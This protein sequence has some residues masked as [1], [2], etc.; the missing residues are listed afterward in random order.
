MAT[1]E[2]Y[3]D[4]DRD[5]LDSAYL[6]NSISSLSRPRSVAQLTVKAYKQATHFFLTKRF[7]EALEQL[8]PIVTP[9]PS[10]SPQSNGGTSTSTSPIEA[11]SAP[12]TQSNKG[13]RTKVWVF[14]FSLLNAIIELG[15]DEGKSSFGSTKWRQLLAKAT[16]GSIWE[17]VVQHGYAGNEGDV[18]PD[19]VVNLATLLL[20]H[21]PDQR[22][23]QHRLETYLSASADA[24]QLSFMQQEGIATPM[25]TGTSSPKE[26]TTRLKILELYTLHV[27]PSNNEWEYAKG[28]IEMNDMLDEEHREAFL[29]ALATLKDEKE[30]L[31]QRE[32]ELEELREREMEEQ[33]VREEARRKDQERREEERKKAAEAERARRPP[34]TPSSSSSTSKAKSTQ[35]PTPPPPPPTKPQKKARVQPPP[36]TTNL[37]TR[38]SSALNNLQQMVLQTSRSV[39]GSNLALARFLIF[40][41]AFILLIARRDLREKVKR[42]LERGFGKVKQTVGMG[43]KVSYI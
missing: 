7:Q 24:A 5:S 2:G 16:D 9:Q 36:I 29:H 12:V 32:R 30:G 15:P 4:R 31:S 20:T 39:T 40:L 10:Q 21:M 37:Y 19:V 14:Y 3:R 23:N 18:D 34:P 22:L 26:L 35:K 28:F 27:L 43:T 1:T 41:L 6:S 13:T 42:G 25:S 33:K 11:R 8:E 17:D 38:A